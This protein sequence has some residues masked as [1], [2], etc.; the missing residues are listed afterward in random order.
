VRL[1]ESIVDRIEPNM[2]ARIR[3]HAIAD[4]VF[5]GTVQDVAPRPDRSDFNKSGIK[6]YPT[7]VQIDQPLPSLYP[8]MT[9]DT[10]IPID[11]LDNVLSVPLNAVLPYDGKYHV[12]VK[13]PGRG[14]Q[15]RD[16]RLGFANNE[17]VEV[18][19]GIKSGETIIVDPITLMSEEERKAKFGDPPSVRLPNRSPIPPILPKK[20]TS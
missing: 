15:W 12:A 4:Q 11:E 9:A 17:Q 6:V 16:V 7:H 19:E 13:Q 1:P 18:W 10:E 8:G 3:V 14:F 20:Q 2:K 5:T